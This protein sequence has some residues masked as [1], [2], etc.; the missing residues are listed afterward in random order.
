MKS[1]RLLFDDIPLTWNIFDSD[2]AMKNEQYPLTIKLNLKLFSLTLLRTVTLRL[3]LSSVIKER[4]STAAVN[5]EIAVRKKF[6]IMLPKLPF[7]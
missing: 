7:Y 3:R 6:P 4:A 5:D 2:L 1:I